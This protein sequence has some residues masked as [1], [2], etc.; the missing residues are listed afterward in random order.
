M[1][2]VTLDLSL[3]IRPITIRYGID[4]VSS[5]ILDPAGTLELPRR[6]WHTAGVRWDMARGLSL[7]GE[8][9]NVFDQ[10]TISVVA[11]SI[12]A[13]YTRYPVSDFIGYPIPGRRFSLSLRYTL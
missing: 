1:H 13:S 8:V 2:D 12:S 6:A 9:I 11:E 3:R 4:I 5:T 7:V 10:R